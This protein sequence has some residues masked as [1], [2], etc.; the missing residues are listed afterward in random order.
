MD[1]E[2]IWEKLEL[3][4]ETGTKVLSNQTMLSWTIN[5]NEDRNCYKYYKREVKNATKDIKWNTKDTLNKNEERNLL[6]EHRGTNTCKRQV[7]N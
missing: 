2:K 6:L 4:C 3:V 5:W 1:C 7:E